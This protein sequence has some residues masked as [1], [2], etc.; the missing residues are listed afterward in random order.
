MIEAIAQEKNLK[1]WK[2]QWKIEL[3]ERHNPNWRDLFEDLIEHAFS[4][5]NVTT[6]ADTHEKFSGFRVK[7]WESPQNTP[8]NLKISGLFRQIIYVLIRTV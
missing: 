6:S 4:V 8:Y 7:P 2:R 1:N 5:K 3:I